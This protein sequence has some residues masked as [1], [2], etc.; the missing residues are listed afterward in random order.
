MSAKRR[1]CQRG[2][3]IDVVEK[4]VGG[5]NAIERVM[6]RGSIERRY[7]KE[8]T[9][10]KLREMLI[11]IP[12]DEEHDAELPEWAI[13]MLIEKSVGYRTRISMVLTHHWDITGDNPSFRFVKQREMDMAPPKPIPRWLAEFRERRMQ[14]ANEY[15]NKQRERKKKSWRNTSRS[16]SR[17]TYTRR[18]SRSGAWSC[19]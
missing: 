18:K 1:E 16:S 13:R 19:T 17:D 12:L 10:R 8:A 7:G 9:A 5:M 4:S 3:G 15:I 6:T 14:I 11:N 2:K